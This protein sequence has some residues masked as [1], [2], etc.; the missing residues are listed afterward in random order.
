MTSRSRIAWIALLVTLL[1]TT[2]LA[3]SLVTVVPGSVQVK[4]GAQVQFS[5]AVSGGDIVLWSVTGSGCAGISC[6]SI[7]YDGLYTAP[8][9][10]PNPSVVTVTATSLFNPAQ[11]GH[12][13]VNLG[14]SSQVGISITP[15]NAA[16]GV[17][18]HLQFSATVTGTSNKSVTW[19]VS[20]TGCVSGSCGSISSSGLYTAP[21]SIPNPS[22]ATITARSSAD[23]TKS[24][25]ASVVI[26]AA[27][28]VSVSVSPASAQVSTN[29]SQQYSATV[30]GSTNTSV[31]WTVSGAACNGSACGTISSSGVYRAPASAPTPPTVTIKATSVADTAASGQ[32]SAIIVSGQALTISPTSPVVKLGAQVQFTASLKGSTSGVVNWSIS[33]SGCA[34]I[35]CGSIDS[36]GLY[37]APKSAPTPPTVAVTATLLSNPSISASS[38]ATIQGPTSVHVAIAPSSAELKTGAQKQFTASVTGTSNTAVKWS[39]NG[40]G[41]SGATCGAISSSG[42]Y[43]APPTVPSPSFVNVVATSVAD[44]SQSDSATVTLTQSINVS[45]SPTA[46]RVV[47][48]GKQQFSATVSGL[49]NSNVTWSVSGKGCVGAACG[50]VLQSGVYTAPSV[51]PNP[52]Q[53]NVTATSDADGVTAASA[54]VTIFAPIVVTVSPTASTLSVNEQAQFRATVT[55]TT[56]T[57]VTWS[58]SG[59]GCSGSSCGSISTAGIYTAPSAIPNPS[60]V[61][62]KAT[63]QADTSRSATVTATVVASNNAKLKGKY[64]FFFTGFDSNGVYEAAGTFTADG[65]GRVVSGTEDVNNTSAPSTKMPINGTYTVGNDSRGVLNI[66][67]SLGANTFRFALNPLGT[68][69]RFISFDNSGTR[70]GGVIER[71]DQTAFDPSVLQGGYA[72]N[73]TGMNEFGQ[74]IGALGLIFPDGS[75]F[76]SGSSLDVNEGGNI[77]PTFATFNG[78]YNVDA[79]GRGTTSLQIPGFDGGTFHFAF[80]VVSANEFLMVSIDPLS[81][82]NPI[83]GG[84]AELQTGAP[85]VASSFQGPSVFSLSGST[86]YAPQDSVGRMVFDGTDNVVAG[87]D[88]NSAGLVNIGRTLVGAYS[89]EINGRGTLNLTDPSTNQTSIWYL[90]AT[91][92]GSA[93][94]M[95]ASTGAVAV[96]EMKTQTAVRP[97]SNGDILGSYAL[98]SDEPIVAT[99]PLYAGAS[100]F[101]GG[102]GT[103]GNGSITGTEDISLATSLQANQLLGGTYAVSSASNNGRG[104]ILLTSP[105]GKTFALWVIS[106]SEAVALD[107]SAGA[108]QPAV[109]HIEQ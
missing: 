18:G 7:T 21:A 102:N 36:T 8:E 109:L 46:A 47:T 103:Q 41:C 50:V 75:G 72:L 101:D 33:G 39:V 66:K 31:T 85:F 5:A 74:R 11:S 61:K 91:A 52:A 20:G 9:V 25:S 4:P 32:A 57:A 89:V 67:N 83:F 37:T 19:S 87:I 23:S 77:S 2:S 13:T 71:Q 105:S 63:S 99:T 45:V 104:S 40:Y 90:Y 55:G 43:I 34:G 100:N 94:L 82:D 35:T 53:V 79:S 24:A 42:L 107:V 38:T 12:A 22:I 98:G 1:Y 14:Q 88:E 76:I 69:G 27:A 86:G 60:S 64:A 108:A 26:Q 96:G 56:N 58:V 78:T 97:F 70:G 29:S 16:V 92:P 65:N 15:T 51:V 49:T 54:T 84:P 30:S 6:G 44:P 73:L 48:D 10:T 68:K 17:K 28:F 93:F 62:I 95:D 106:A 80:Y 59:A 81:G 3:A